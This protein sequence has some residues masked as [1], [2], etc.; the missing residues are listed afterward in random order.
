MLTADLL[1]ARR[2]NNWLYPRYVDIDKPQLQH[3][4]TELV[5][6]FREAHNQSPGM[7]RGVLQ[8]SIDDLVGAHADPLLFRGLCKLLFDRCEF[9]VP[10]EP[11]PAQL[12]QRVFLA[13]AKLRLR[14]ELGHTWVEK[15]A[16]LIKEL[17][18]ELHLGEDQL[19][20][21]LYADLAA[22]QRL[23]QFRDV[24]PTSLLHRYNLALAQAVLL[25][26]THMTVELEPESVGA[27]RQLFQ[28]L[29][30]RQLIHTVTQQQDGRFLIELD[31][32][33]SLFASSSRYGLAM[34]QFL[35]TLVLMPRFRLE[36]ELRWGKE[37]SPCRF[38]L[39]HKR[40]LKSHVKERGQYVTDEQKWFEER[41]AKKSGDWE[42]SRCQDILQTE[43]GQ[44]VIPDL[45]FENTSD[46]RVGYL[47]IV[48]FWRRG[49]LDARIGQ[50]DDPKLS[51]LVL[52]VSSRLAGEKKPE[53]L[54]HPRIVWFK[55]VIMA[56]R[57]REALDQ[58]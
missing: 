22:N 8:E 5:R 49:T 21:G 12:R 46:G 19:E 34:A 14:R 31:G 52:A 32:P 2:R 16:E 36:A 23:T 47:E 18:A 39:D 11:E 13:S 27:Y 33:L 35:P 57:V 53:I 28:A 42:M 17:A 48:G 26:A 4:A 30:F 41:F 58:L 9:G 55:Q 43:G 29:K 37:R 1:R 15:R 50:L 44:V 24:E 54:E 7:R 10:P 56:D 25:R 38:S 51:E 3:I 45:Q 20:E 6:L 40:K